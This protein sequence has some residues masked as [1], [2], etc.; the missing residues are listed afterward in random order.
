MYGSEALLKIIDKL[1]SPFIYGKGYYV[2]ATCGSRLGA[3]TGESL[4]RADFKFRLYYAYSVTA[5][6]NIDRD[7][8]VADACCERRCRIYEEGAIS[9]QRGRKLPHANRGHAEREHFIEHCYGVGAIR[10]ASAHAGLRR[11]ILGKP[12]VNRRKPG[13]HRFHQVVCF[14]DEIVLRGAFYPYAV[15]VYGACVLCRNRSLGDFKFVT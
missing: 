9:S 7:K 11:D 1:P 2:F 14:Y 3:Y 10:R 5:K 8:L 12:N 6:I 4:F 13:V 15:N